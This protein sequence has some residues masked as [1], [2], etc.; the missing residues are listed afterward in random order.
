[1]RSSSDL[2]SFQQP[3]GWGVTATRTQIVRQR[4][5]KG[6][7]IKWPLVNFSTIRSRDRSSIAGASHARRVLHFLCVWQR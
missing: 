3:S 5:T 1:M 4:R 2:P 6:R 7:L